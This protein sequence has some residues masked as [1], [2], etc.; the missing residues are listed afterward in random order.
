[1]FKK[2]LTLLL[3]VF[4]L[5]QLVSCSK[6][7]DPAPPVSDAYQTVV[8]DTSV[9]E[10]AAQASSQHKKAGH[11]TFQPK[12]CSSLMEEVM[13]T[14][15]KEAYF[16][17]VDAVMEGRD[18][19]DCPDQYTYDWMMGQFAYRCFPVLAEVIEPTYNGGNDVVD[20]KASYRWKVSEEDGRRKIN[21]FIAL[22]ESILN[23]TLE[24]DYTDLEKALAL[25]VWFEDH[26]EYDYET[27]YNMYEEAPNYTSG[28]RL[29]TEGIGICQEISTAYSFLLMQAGVDATIIFDSKSDSLGDH[30]W[31][32]V[33][34]NG[35]TYHIDPTFV[36]QSNH[37]L[38]YFMMSDKQRFGG[39]SY[40]PEDF[41]LASIYSYEHAHPVHPAEDDFFEP[42]WD[43][44][45]VSF[46]HDNHKLYCQ[47]FNMDSEPELIEFD[48]SGF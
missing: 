9:E 8:S 23:E 48:Y 37:Y 30:Q 24:D 41:V 10:L 46:D 27:Y 39:G 4:M 29:M 26:Y 44:Y 13:G 11:Y 22:T 6:A 42:V 36:L 7:P 20:G 35:N 28:Y 3:A 47:Y 15:L 31:S 5:I 34:I 16:N 40:S 19:F 38:G 25:Y 14:K 18:T 33:R 45:F 2:I 1:M 17:F 43:T 12:V 32:Y 21:E